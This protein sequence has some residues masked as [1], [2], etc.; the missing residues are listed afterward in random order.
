MWPRNVLR[1]DMTLF[2]FNRIILPKNAYTIPTRLICWFIYPNSVKRSIGLHIHKVISIKHKKFSENNLPFTI[3]SVS[4]WHKIKLPLKTSFPLL[5]AVIKGIFSAQ[6]PTT[7]HM[8]V[9]LKGIEF[10]QDI[11]LHVFFPFSPITMPFTI[12][13]CMLSSCTLK[14]PSYI[15]VAFSRDSIMHCG[16][17]LFYNFRIYY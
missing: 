17:L 2:S 12:S 11:F 14:Y 5:N 3:C 6:F 9:F 1:Y 4:F 8:I 10:I 15:F 13:F 7:R 16:N